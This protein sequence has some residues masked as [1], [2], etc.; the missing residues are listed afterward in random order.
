[1][2]R[3]IAKDADFGAAFEKDHDARHKEMKSK[4]V[5]TLNRNGRRSYSSL[6][7]AMNNWCSYKTIER[8]LKSSDDF[9]TYSQNVRPLLFESNRL[10]QVVFSQHVRNRWGLGEGNRIL[11]TIR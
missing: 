1:M 5:D 11:W 7:K 3:R 9:V 6:E 4:L 2:L 10:K 8:F